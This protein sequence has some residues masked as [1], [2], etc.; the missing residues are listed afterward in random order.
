MAPTASDGAAQAF[1][2][3][4]P[5]VAHFADLGGAL[6]ALPAGCPVSALD[7][8]EAP[9]RIRPAA[10]LPPVALAF[11]PERGWSPRERGL[12]RSAGFHLVHLGPRVLRTETAVVAAVAIVKAAS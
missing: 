7:N 2:T 4:L 11:G 8:Y 12:L 10:D 1:D 9:A 3:R 6:A 5:E